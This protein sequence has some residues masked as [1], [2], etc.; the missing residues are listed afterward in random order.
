M[1]KIGSF[2]ARFL[3]LSSH[4]WC[5]CSFEHSRKLVFACV[6]PVLSIFWVC[7]P[8]GQSNCTSDLH[9]WSAHMHN[10]CAASCPLVSVFLLSRCSFH[11]FVL[12]TVN[13]QPLS[14]QRLSF[15]SL[16]A[17]LVLET[18]RGYCWRLLNLGFRCSCPLHA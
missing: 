7:T 2:Q 9:I 12:V 11:T 13:T 10:S 4:L 1:K 16:E 3:S 17:Q 18:N 6:V 15:L 14:S 8:T 5:S